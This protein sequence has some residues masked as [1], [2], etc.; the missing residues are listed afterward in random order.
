MAPVLEQV[1]L[2]ES[3]D[4]HAQ[5]ARGSGTPVRQPDIRHH[6]RARL[7]DDPGAGARTGPGPGIRA[8]AGEWWNLPGGWVPLPNTPPTNPGPVVQFPPPTGL[9]VTGTGKNSVSLLWTTVPSGT[10][11]PTSYTVAIYDRR[12]KIA[13]QTTVNTPDTTGGQGTATVT[14]LQPKSSYHANVWANGGTTA[15]RHASVAFNTTS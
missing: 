10:R 2:A 1:Q 5:Y 11:Y 14:G 6:Y 12:G 7:P 13:S 4:D 3:A 15:P 9:R 8:G